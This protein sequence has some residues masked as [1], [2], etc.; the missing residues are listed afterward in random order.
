MEMPE[1]YLKSTKQWLY[2]AFCCI[3]GKLITR[4]IMYTSESTISLLNHVLENLCLRSSEHFNVVH[5]FYHQ[6]NKDHD[7]NNIDHNNNNN[8]NN[9]ND[10]NHNYNSRIN[11]NSNHINDISNDINS[12][13]NINNFINNGNKNNVNN[14]ANI[15]NSFISNNINNEVDNNIN[16]NNINY[17]KFSNNNINYN[18]YNNLN[19]NINYNNNYLNYNNINNNNLNNHNNVNNNDHNNHNHNNHMTS[20]ASVVTAN[21]GDVVEL[22]CAPHQ[23]VLH[24]PMNDGVRGGG[25]D[26]GTAAADDSDD[27]NDDDDDDDDDVDDDEKSNDNDEN[28]DDEDDDD[29]DDDM[30]NSHTQIWSN[31]YN[32]YNSQS[33][34]N[35]NIKDFETFKKIFYNQTTDH[36]KSNNS[37]HTN[38]NHSDITNINDDQHLDD[39]LQFIIKW[40]KSSIEAPIVTYMPPMPAR[41]DLTYSIKLDIV[42]VSGIRQILMK[43]HCRNFHPSIITND[44]L[45]EDFFK[46]IDVMKRL[47]FSCFEK[48]LRFVLL[49]HDC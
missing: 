36:T 40:K 13:N 30:N 41:I 39:N 14:N 2:I 8:K 5:K 48:M 32:H 16:Y 17:N 29:D 12:Y 46:I 23:S 44:Q 4:N 28:A 35:K 9:I 49:L 22:K 20:N 42:N 1:N 3:G 15:R 26:D 10:I 18:N 27:E 21:V 7:H 31:I 24:V 11:I 19:N 6:I 34:P 25:D 45:S 43:I 47:R 37:S 33:Y 38:I